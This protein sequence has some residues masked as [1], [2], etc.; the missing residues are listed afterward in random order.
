VLELIWNKRLIVDRTG[1]F[2]RSQLGDLLFTVLFLFALECRDVSR[3]GLRGAGLGLGLPK[4]SDRFRVCMQKFFFNIQS[5]GFFV[6]YVDLLY[7][8]P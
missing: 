8:P 5:N 7:S 6:R 2:I 4:V 3:A 1:N